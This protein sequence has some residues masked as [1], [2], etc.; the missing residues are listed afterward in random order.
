M[1]DHRL[2]ISVQS[3][4]RSKLAVSYSV[5]SAILHFR[6]VDQAIS[7]FIS[8]VVPKWYRPTCP[9]LEN[10][11]GE[12]SRT[13]DLQLGKLSLY[14]LSY[15][16]INIRYFI[17]GHGSHPTGSRPIHLPSSPVLRILGFR[18]RVSLFH[19]PQ[20]IRCF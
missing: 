20:P 13:P 1:T 19:S 16:R 12:E 3:I 7:E 6:R 5:H 14:Q 17:T 10:L 9:I 15:T 18:R 8:I 2:F 4:N 11:A